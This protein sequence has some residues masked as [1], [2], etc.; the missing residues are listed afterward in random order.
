MKKTLLFLVLLLTFV[1]IMTLPYWIGIEVERY[2]TKGNQNLFNSVNLQLL[3][4][5]YQRG[6]FTSKA[7]STVEVPNNFEITKSA[8]I[9]SD[10]YRFI[11]EH[12]IEHGFQPITSTLIHTSLRTH[13]ES[14][15]IQQIAN[16]NNGLL[17]DILTAVQTNG[18]SVSTL[19][20]PT[21]NIRDQNA[22][23]QW[24]G[25]QG[26]VS[27]QRNLTQIETEIY[28]PQ[29]QLET[30]EGQIVIQNIFL[31]AT[32]QPSEMQGKGILNLGKIRLAGQQELPIQIEG[33]KLVG[34]NQIVA[35][36][37]AYQGQ[38]ELQ[39]IQVGATKY[40]PSDSHFEFQHWH[41]PTLNQLKNTWIAIRRQNL[42]PEME[43]KI[44]QMRLTPYGLKLL[45]QS[46][47]LAMTHF[48]FNMPEGEL[49]GTLHARMEPFEE[50]FS[51]L[52]NPQQVLF[53]ALNVHLEL[54]VPQIWLDNQDKDL[55]AKTSSHI[56]PSLKQYLQAWVDKGILILDDN[57][58][59]LYHSQMH[60]KNGIL[61]INGQA[62]PLAILLN[63]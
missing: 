46:P 20:M 33:I 16:S 37:L 18:D 45:S 1:A 51:L 7:Q 38:I 4:N 58:S 62:V 59:N 57:Q 15:T 47:E 52:F 31:T 13:S 39:Q 30:T 6:W 23:L 63:K 29:I 55:L 25:L 40:G 12:E 14:E 44:V 3:D 54:S 60:L 41:L 5:S 35:D 10:N 34:E 49:H 24:Q 21:I 42:A 11:F 28:S 32:M 17:L 9:S 56:E 22:H 26:H 61:H 2:F 50:V 8:K 19:K 27:I 53:K 43:A 36:Y 48:K